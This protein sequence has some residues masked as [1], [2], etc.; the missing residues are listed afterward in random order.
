MATI[1]TRRTGEKMRPLESASLAAPTVSGCADQLVREVVRTVNEQGMPRES[2]NALEIKE[3]LA[4][5]TVLTNPLARLLCA[6]DYP[7]VFNPGLAVARFFYLISGSHDLDEIA[8]YSPSARRFTDDG[9]T[10]PGGAHGYRLFYPNAATDQ[11]E[12]LVRALRKH[13]ERNRGAVS[14]YHPQDCGSESADLTCVMG[15]LFSCKEGRLRTLI[16]MRA[17]DA[18]RLLWYD[19]FEFSMLGEFV[20]RYCGFELGEYYH[21]SFVMMLIGRTAMNIAENIQNDTRVSPPMMP[22]PEVGPDTRMHLVRRERTIRT[23]VTTAD[24]DSFRRS[25]DHLEEEEN[26]YWADLLTSLAIQGRYVNVTPAVAARELATI[27]VPADYVVTG[28]VLDNSRRIAAQRVDTRLRRRL[29]GHPRRPGHIGLHRVRPRDKRAAAIAR[30]WTVP[31]RMIT[32]SASGIPQSTIVICVARGQIPP[33]ISRSIGASAPAA[34]AC[35]SAAVIAGSVPFRPGIPEML[36]E[37]AASSP[38]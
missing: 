2:D 24:F 17:N 21:S 8:F 31:S 15:G 35:T 9:L 28:E 11:F 6:P 1:I 34:K 16:N 14:F 13:P 29:G 37:L 10:M 3:I 4:F 7:Q 5:N 23:T 27:Q 22:M 30:R 18:L 12:G 36:A 32:G 19:M 25:V 38:G 26:P 33:S 20:A